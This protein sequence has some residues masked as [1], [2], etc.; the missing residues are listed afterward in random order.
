MD[1]LMKVLRAMNWTLELVVTGL[2]I[3]ALGLIL[4]F[5]YQNE[6]DVTKVGGNITVQCEPRS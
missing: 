6:C 1:K 4:L 5:S 3:T 2:G